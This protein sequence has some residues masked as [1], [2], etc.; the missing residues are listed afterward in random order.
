VALSNILVRNCY[1]EGFLNNVRITREGFRDLAEGVEYDHAFSNI[2]VEDSTFV[3][4][5]GV[6]VFVD[7][8][9]TDVTLRNLHIEGSGSTGIYLEAGSKDNVV[10]NNVIATRR[11]G[12]CSTS[13]CRAV[14]TMR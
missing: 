10:E 4:S 7:G 13:R 3:N 1:V 8:Y 5:R 11:A 12:G 14:R 6:G 9:V 2:V